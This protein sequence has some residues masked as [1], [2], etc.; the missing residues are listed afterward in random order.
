M[1]GGIGFT[2]SIFIATLAFESGAM[3]AAA[4]LAVL[5][6]SGLAAVIAL[7]FGRI[8]YRSAFTVDSKDS[9]DEPN[10]AG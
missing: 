5:I 10:Y 4:K 7:G 3:L 8:A 6:A 1:L 9:P 2:M